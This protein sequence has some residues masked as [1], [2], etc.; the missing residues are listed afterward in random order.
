AYDKQVLVGVKQSLT[1]ACAIV[2]ADACEAVVVGKTEVAVGNACGADGG[3]GDDLGTV[4][5]RAHALAGE[6]LRAHAFAEDQD[7]GP[8]ARGLLAGAV[9]QFS[10]ADAMRK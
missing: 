3:M 5:E 10:S 4:V 2:D 6:E 1:G 8:E 7:F 9:G